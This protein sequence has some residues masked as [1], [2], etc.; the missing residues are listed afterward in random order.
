MKKHLKP[1]LF[2]AL[3]RSGLGPLMASRY[4]GPGVILMFHEMRRDPTAS[5]NI[6]TAPE[7]LDFTL[8]CL[9][10]QGRD[11]VDL[12][13][14][15]ARLTSP[16]P[17]PFAVVTFD[18][19]YRD[20]Q[21]LALPI[22]ERHNAAATI[23]VPTEMVDRSINAWWLGL[24]TLF[25]TRDHVEIAPMAK[26]FALVDFASRKAG[27]EEV[28]AWI[29]ADFTRADLMPRVFADAGLDLVDLVD[30]HALSDSEL[31]AVA[32]HPLI[33]IGAHTQSHR[34]LAT[35]STDGQHEELSCNKTFLESLLGQEVAHLA[36]PYGRPAITG[37]AEAAL[38]RQLGFRTAVTTDPGH[39]FPAH[40]R[41]PFLLPRENGESDGWPQLRI[42]MGL[43]GVFHALKSGFGS[44]A[45]N[46][47]S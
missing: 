1:L 32:E 25:M 3:M 24:R 42:E 17:R 26:R 35:L 6:G 11:I 36:Y 12:D 10:R 39:L 13:E 21:T 43:C 9:K 5:F 19:G 18:D 46:I 31:K 34:A 47:S 44:P 45:A 7:T 16:Q 29:W 38:A 8:R 22:L 23:Y 15:L 27:Y 37:P 28:I 4:R 14:A 41:D 40:G 33:T 30:R 2:Y 20:N